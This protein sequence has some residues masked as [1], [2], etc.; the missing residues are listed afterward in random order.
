M[1][2]SNWCFIAIVVLACPSCSDEPDDRTAQMTVDTPEGKKTYSVG[3]GKDGSMTIDGPDGKVTYTAD[4][5]GMRTTVTNKDGT[6]QVTEMSNQVD[7][8]TFEGLLHAGA[9]LENGNESVFKMSGPDGETATAQ[10]VTADSPEKVRDQYKKALPGAM[11]VEA[12][13]MTSISGTRPDGA[14][15]SITIGTDEESRKTKIVVT[16]IRQKK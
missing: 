13:G 12:G 15:Y 7:L 9:T 16:L 5:K 6:T 11:S 3:T 4:E 14:N 10:F 8:A 1:K 2:P